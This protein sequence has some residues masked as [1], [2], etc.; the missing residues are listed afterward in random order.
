MRRFLIWIAF[1]LGLGPAVALAALELPVI[2]L[3]RVQAK[4]GLFLG[5]RLSFWENQSEPLDPSQVFEGRYDGNFVPSAKDIPGP[6]FIKGE[7][8]L[9]IVIHNPEASPQSLMLESRYALT[10]HISFYQKDPDGRMQVDHQGDRNELRTDPFPFR[11]PTF[12]VK[13]YPGTNVYYL[14]TESRGTNILSLYLWREAAFKGHHFVDTL[15]IG[16]L[17]GFLIALFFYNSF[18]ALSL[19]SRTYAYYTLFLLC[20]IL[21]Q[22]AMQNIW[23][24]LVQPRISAWL[25][26]EGY[27]V[28]GSLTNFSGILFTIYFL[29]LKKTA[30]GFLNFFRGL[31]L[32]ALAPILLTP[33]IDFNTLTRIVSVTVGIGSLCM[34]ITSVVAMIRGYK[35]AAYYFLASVTFL[36][37]NI[38]LT[39]NLLGIYHAPHVIQYGNFIGLVMQGLLMSLAV[40]H[41][42]QFIRAQANRLIRGLNEELQNHLAQVEGLV[43]ER[44]ETIRTILDNVAS[45]FVI[46]A[47]NG[48]IVKG[49]SQSCHQLLGRILQEG[50]RFSELLELDPFRKKIWDLAWSQIFQDT[51]PASV[52]LAQ[53]PSAIKQGGRS[54]RL[55]CKILRDETGGIKN[56]LFTIQD[57]T[58]LKKQKREARRHR[59]LIKI[60]QDIEAFRQ[61]IHH[62]YDFIGRLKA[63][64]DA[65]E[66][67]FLL[68]TLKGNSMVFGLQAIAKRLHR[69]EEG[70]QLSAADLQTLENMFRDFLSAHDTILKTVWGPNSQHE[71]RV[72]LTQLQQLENLVD[73]RQE[74]TLQQDV[75]GW[76]QDV[77]AKPVHMIVQ[78]IVDSSQ[79]LAF[80]LNRP[81]T[82][83]VIGGEVRVR[84]HKEEM[85]L[86]FL[87]HILRNAIVHGLD[88]DRE[89]LGKNP[90]AHIH[91]EFSESPEALRLVIRDDGRGFDRSYWE[92]RAQ[93][94]T[95]KPAAAISRL[96]WVDLIEVVSRGGHSTQ[97][98][99]SMEAGRG[100]GLEGVIQAIRELGGHIHLESTS[101]H[102]STVELEI[103]RQLTHEAA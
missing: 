103:K 70:R 34:I 20:M 67:A 94:L 17:F 76:I 80:R 49:F 96:S 78:P 10:D 50:Q 87:V 7:L 8:W 97:K 73:K 44:T 15:I 56:L 92:E 35:P 60:L 43:A 13:A 6:T 83:Q 9:R 39:F 91:V 1:W 59:I 2:D 27:V 32:F 75:R 93:E 90:K 88:E 52:S 21:L 42:V 38:F 47:P 16:G 62:S 26:N 84:S 12:T 24:Y 66:Q 98:S 69:L 64:V 86:E 55:D 74:P 61:F 41:R 101:G 81:V 57:V 37:A 31:L 4:Q 29:S 33:F 72:T 25:E 95:G 14:R 99:V 65:R 48:T 79:S 58:E 68:H 63:S 23:P 22:I 45:G 51:M 46:V 82:I 100:V 30:P 53:L 71:T 28:V 19:R 36:A 18:L 54:L 11:S 102:G 5:A 85:A 40:G 77:L 3:A 89:R